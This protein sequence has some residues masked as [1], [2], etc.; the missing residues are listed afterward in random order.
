[1]IVLSFKL[2]TLMIDNIKMAFK[3]FA[4][5]LITI[6]DLLLC[7][8][9][10]YIGTIPVWILTIGLYPSKSPESLSDT[11][12]MFFSIFGVIFIATIFVVAVSFGFTS[13]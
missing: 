10:Y 9:L 7:K 11:Q 8:P 3:Y 4:L 12:K 1:M 5:I 2:G 13:I 6:I